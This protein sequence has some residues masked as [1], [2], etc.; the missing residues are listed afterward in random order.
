MSVYVL[1]HPSL[2]TLE[3]DV[4]A[5]TDTRAGLFEALRLGNLAAYDASYPHDKTSETAHRVYAAD[6]RASRPS[7]DTRT[8]AETLSALQALSYNLIDNS[9]QLHLS[10]DWNAALREAVQGVAF[11]CLTP[12][13]PLV[14]LGSFA[15]IAR[16]PY[17]ADLTD[18]YQ[19]F[20]DENRERPY[21]MNATG[22][23]NALHA[24]VYPDAPHLAFRAAWA[25]E[26]ACTLD[27]D[28]NHRAALHAQAVK[29][30]VLPADAPMF[31]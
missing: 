30:G 9:G 20:S 7:L 28:A 29:L 11:E 13:G 24:S 27:W 14:Q 3:R 16:L 23:P 21:L 1:D 15:Y 8:A 5:L 18:R 4:N 25:L 12:G 6:Y 10:P 19:V 31:A 22:K 17:A 26:D 2:K